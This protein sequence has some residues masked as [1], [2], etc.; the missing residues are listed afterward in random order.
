MGNQSVYDILVLIPNP[1]LDV[2]SKYFSKIVLGASTR[3][4]HLYHTFGFQENVVVA[5][6]GVLKGFVCHYLSLTFQETL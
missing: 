4:H 6:H 1:F 2:I 5:L 3:L